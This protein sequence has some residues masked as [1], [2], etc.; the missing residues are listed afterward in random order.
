MKFYMSLILDV[1][2]LFPKPKTSS[3]KFDI[4]NPEEM[5]W[6]ESDRKVGKNMLSQMI[7]KLCQILERPRKTNH[8]LRATAVM[9][10]RRAGLS[11][12]TIIKITGH[13][14]A[15]TLVKN[16]DLRLEAPGLAEVAHAIGSGQD[17]ALGGSVGKVALRT[18][19]RGSNDFDDD[20]S[21]EDTDEESLEVVKVARHGEAAPKKGLEAAKGCTGPSSMA[22]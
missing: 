7:P 14:N 8:C 20:I 12:E 19:K 11:W 22:V 10:M 16:Y 2:Y 1:E 13:K 17:V 15:V 4:H 5:S 18:R 21:L 3:K 6:F 9:Y